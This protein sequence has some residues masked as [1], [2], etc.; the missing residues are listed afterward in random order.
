VLAATYE[1]ALPNF[2]W[3]ATDVRRIAEREWAAEV[4]SM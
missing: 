2:K 1:K 4:N 3:V